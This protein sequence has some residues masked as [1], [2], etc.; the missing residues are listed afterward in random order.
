LTNSFAVAIPMLLS[1][2]VMSAVFPSSSPK[3]FFLLANALVQ[4]CYW[5]FLLKLKGAS[6]RCS[7]N[8]SCVID[9]NFS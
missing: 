9:F 2:P 7:L 3:V 5:T 8:D 4:T 1:T 6:R